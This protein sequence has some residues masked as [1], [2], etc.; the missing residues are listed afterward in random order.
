ML[1]PFDAYKLYVAL[2]NHFSKSSYDF[3]KYNGK[4]KVNY[5]S[6]VNRKDKVFFQ[7]LAKHENLQSFLVANFTHNHKLWVKDLAYSEQAEKL[8]KEWIKKQQSLTYLF[9]NDLE[10]LDENFNTN[11]I[12]SDNQHPIILKLLLSNEIS[13]ETFCIL[14]KLTKS[15]KYLNNNLENDPVWNMIKIK[16]EKYTP[17]IEFDEEKLRNICFD[18]FS[19]T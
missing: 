13:L 1:D 8:Y 11:F 4:V 7:K 9:K 6:F 5:D 18:K 16:V 17:F 10:K 14:L 3:F 19:S 2:K 15:I 12:V